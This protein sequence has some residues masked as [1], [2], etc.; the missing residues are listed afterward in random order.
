M[1]HGEVMPD[2][3]DIILSLQEYYLLHAKVGATRPSF[4]NSFAN[5]CCITEQFIDFVEKR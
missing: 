2:A 5:N 4:Q 1:C 3:Q